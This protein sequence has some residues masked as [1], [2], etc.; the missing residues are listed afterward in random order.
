VLERDELRRIAEAI[1][2]LPQKT[3]QIFTL[4]RVH[5]L[6]QRQIAQQLGVPESTVEKHISRG[7]HLLMARFGRGGKPARRASSNRGEQTG[8]QATDRSRD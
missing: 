4:R 1:A 2:E 5:G 7:I 6:S 8:R 3:A